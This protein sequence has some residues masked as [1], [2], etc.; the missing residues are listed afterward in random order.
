MSK[1]VYMVTGGAGFIG[2]HIAERLLRDGHSVRVLD[3]LHT[4][5]ASTLEALGALGGDF[6][7][8]I[9][10]ISDGDSLRPYFKGVEVVFHQAALPSV[11]LSIVEPQRTH[12]VCAGGTLNVLRACVAE[13]VRRVVYA[14]SSSAYGNRDDA[15]MSEA[16]APAPISPYGA[17]KLAGEMYCHAF[18][19]SYPLETVILRYFNVFGARQDPS[20][21]YAA[22]IPKFITALLQGER[23]TIYGDG[24]QTR[25]FVHVANVVHANLLAAEAP[26]ANRQTF[27]VGTGEGISLLDL[28]QALNDLLGTDVTPHFAPTRAGDIRH[29]VASIAHAKAL[30]AYTPVV[31]FKE[32]LAQTLAWYQATQASQ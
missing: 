5:K 3:N 17:A 29:S 31:A 30:L 19:H 9:A 26:H 15:H 11:P 7:P 13:G 8:I 1:H 16:F 32:G 14:G 2:S 18:A 21:H 28:M 23:P 10:D 24:M 22:V 25:D 27:N 12:E 4:G 6:T 20:S